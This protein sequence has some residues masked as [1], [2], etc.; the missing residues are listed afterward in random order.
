MCLYSDQDKKR[1]V[2]WELTGLLWRRGIT[3]ESFNVESEDLASCSLLASCV[4]LGKVASFQSLFPI[5]YNG[6]PFLM[7]VMRTEMMFVKWSTHVE[8]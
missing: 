5:C 1:K 8:W 6:S 7:C 2:R 4:M 3:E